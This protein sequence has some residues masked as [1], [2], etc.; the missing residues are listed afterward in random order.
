MVKLLGDIPLKWSAWR[1]HRSWKTTASKRLPANS[2]GKNSPDKRSLRC[3]K[4]SPPPM[5]L[6]TSNRLRRRRPATHTVMGNTCRGREFEDQRM[7]PTVPGPVD[8]RSGDLRAVTSLGAD[9]TSP[10]ACADPVSG[11]Y[12]RLDRGRRRCRDAHTPSPSYCQPGNS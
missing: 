11:P 5:W 12:K 1:S 3:S 8:R 10:T 7:P 4:E 9:C 2:M 6:R